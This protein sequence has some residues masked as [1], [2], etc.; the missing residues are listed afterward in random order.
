MN[1]KLLSFVSNK[2]GNR[3]I[4]HAD[5]AGLDLLIAE[6]TW[7]RKKLEEDKCDHTHLR[8][9]D[10][11]GDE[12]TTTKL[13]NQE[14]EVHTVHEVKIYGWNQEWKKKHELA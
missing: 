13:K 4:V 7:L 11:V 3:V 10:W 12:L 8:S 6:L 5:K 1:S 2:E 9:E 14:E